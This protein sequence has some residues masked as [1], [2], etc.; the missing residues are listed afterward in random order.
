[1]QAE[2]SAA[3]GSVPAVNC[4]SKMPLKD[5]RV[6]GAAAAGLL[7]GFL[8]G[9]LVFGAPWHL[10]P[11]WGD[12]PTWIL[13]VGAA[14][15]AWITL[16]QLSDLRGQ[17]AEEAKRNQRRDQL[18]DKQLA[19]AEARE[20]SERRRLVEDVDVRF[21]PSEGIVIN[22]SRRPLVDITC[23][24][25]SEADRHV[26]ATAD[27]CGEIVPTP[28]GS[29]IFVPV[30]GEFRFKGLRPGA[31]CA[32]SFKELAREPDQVLVV[33]FTDD[34]GFR[35]QLDQY[36]HLVRSEDEDRYMS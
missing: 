10:P 4:E 12:I 19:E 26:L 22:N 6:L 31:R 17:I 5:R 34:A 3:G 28:G 24:V 27:G 2:L 1:L 15:T 23:K 13:A 14:A 21:H 11:A 8:I 36:L 7:A 35:W 25:M 33:W 32:F 30:E 18:L 29:A 9:L 16:L 20:E